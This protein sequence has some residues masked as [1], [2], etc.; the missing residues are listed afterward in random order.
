MCHYLIPRVPFGVAS[1]PLC[2][3]VPVLVVKCLYSEWYS[4]PLVVSH[5]TLK[6]C[7][8]SFPASVL[9]PDCLP[10]FPEY[11]YLLLSAFSFLLF[12]ISNQMFVFNYSCLLCG[13]CWIVCCLFLLCRLWVCLYLVRF[14]DF[15]CL[16]TWWCFLMN[17]QESCSTACFLFLM[18]CLGSSST[19]WVQHTGDIFLLSGFT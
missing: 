5:F 12:P 19:K 4:S 9:F 6:V 2:F 14:E 11:F 1:I 18:L 15:F 7:F 10:W 17:S 16:F 8:L 13:L 3:P